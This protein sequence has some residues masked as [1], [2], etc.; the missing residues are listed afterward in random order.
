VRTGLRAGLRLAGLLPALVVIA[1][2]SA[3][4]SKFQSF[5]FEAPEGARIQIWQSGRVSRESEPRFQPAVG[6]LSSPE[7]RLAST[8]EV[9][10]SG[11]S[12]ALTYTS[13]LP[14]CTLS[15][16]SD[17]AKVLATASLPRTSGNPLR[18]LV[19]LQ[20]GS[21]IWGYQISASPSTAAGTFTLAGAGVLAFVHGFSVDPGL[22]TVDGSVEVLSTSTSETTAR[23]TDATRREM[24]R[25]IWLLRLTLADGAAGGRVELS[26]PDGG[27]AVF[28]VN[29]A[30]TPGWLDFGRGSVAFLP[31]SVRFAGALRGLQVLQ[32]P[33]E[34]PIPAD[35]GQILAWDRSSW[36]KPDYELY[37]WSRYPRVL[38]MDTASYEVQDAFFKR[39]AFFVEK[40]GH[41]GKLESRS[42]LAGLHGYNAHDYRAEDL[43]RFF[44]EARK[45]AGGLS[46]EEN[47][48]AGILAENGVLKQTADGYAPGDGCVLSISRSS[49]PILRAL[50]LTHESFHGLFFTM[51]SFRDATEKE[52]AALSPD[53][54][55]LWVDYLA[56]RDYDTTDHYL[57]VNEFQSYLL[58][59]NRSG[60]WGFQNSTMDRLKAAGG[61]DAGLARRVTTAHSASFLKSFDALDGALQSAGGP[62][63]GEAISIRRVDEPA[64]N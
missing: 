17:H 4:S 62:P 2:T 13:D 64:S 36:R 16:F 29:P 38:I 23:L 44:M 56:A 8:V 39:L 61:R 57:V 7:Y 33:A 40:A 34:A 28:D 27:H 47:A 32:L 35:P 18:F 25:G 60:I 12:F 6:R 20:A 5:Q 50:L 11:E 45:E 48:L 3:C 55:A 46:T 22:L 24:E 52:W 15:V 14:A 43:A 42:A 63:G 59:Q 21:R 41:A 51:P 26:N 10:S 30:S 53:E 19:P 9:V 1:L 58:Q 31:Q 54:Q 49:S 37:S